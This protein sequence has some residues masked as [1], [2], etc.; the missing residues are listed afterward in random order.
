[1]TAVNEVS[2]GDL[3]LT[4]VEKAITDAY[5]PQYIRQPRVLAEVKE[6][7][8][9][10]LLMLG[11]MNGAEELHLRR[12]ER[13]IF[14]AL[15]QGGV[16]PGSGLMVFV[17]PKSDPQRLESYD[18]S[19]PQDS[20]QALSRP[21]LEDGDIVIAR[22]APPPM[23]YVHGLAGGGPLPLPANGLRLRQA[24]AAVGGPPTEFD[25]DKVAL[26]RQLHDGRD[27]CVVFKWKDVVDGLE[28]NVELRA[29]DVIEVPHTAETRTE[30]FIRRAIV[31]RTG[32]NAVWD[33]INYYFPPRLENN[34][35]YDRYYSIRHVLAQDVALRAS[36]AI[37][38]FGP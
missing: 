1:M 14:Q 30:E 20:M 35:Y 32:I 23:V 18:L 22:N 19:L 17:Q 9:I 31:F 10:K 38:P 37:A 27:V 13:S 3:T 2:V 5:S 24:I 11:G 29:G 8:T 25:I 28:P 16:V 15:A 36:R 33:P 34:D 7:H 4:G 6:Y 21:A 26:T 12:N